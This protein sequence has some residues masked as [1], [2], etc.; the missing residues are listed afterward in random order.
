MALREK[1]SSPTFCFFAFAFLFFF[2]S[3]LEAVKESTPVAKGVIKPSSP[4]S[5]LPVQ[6]NCTALLGEKSTA[7]SD[8]DIALKCHKT[9]LKTGG[10]FQSLSRCGSHEQVIFCNDPSVGLKAIVALHSTALGPA[11]GGCRVYPY[12]SEEEAL[13]DV[14]RLSKGMTY[15][16]AISGLNFGGGKMVVIADPKKDKSEA[17]LRSLGRF[18][19]SLGGQFITGED[20]GMT[21]QDVDTMLLETPYVMG[22]STENGG[23]GNPGEYTAYGVFMGMKAVS[24]YLFERKDGNVEGLK[25][26]VQGLGNVGSNLVE[27]LVR[28]GAEVTVADVDQAKVSWHKDKYQVEVVET[29]QIAQ[30]ESDIFAPCALGAVVNAHSIPLLGCKAIA[31]SANNQLAESEHGEELQKK[32]ILYAPDYVINAGGLISVAS[33]IDTHGFLREKVLAQINNIYLRLM[34]IFEGAEKENT[35]T[36]LIADQMAEERIQAV[37]GIREKKHLKH[38][39]RG[40]QRE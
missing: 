4:S 1:S 40:E 15:K 29:E 32:G 19:H 33:E 3:F 18:M 6:R 23:A 22:V 24:K 16:N 27:H 13:I 34:E 8:K 25:I 21:V 14:L 26:A 36:H 20:M 17:M 35:S 37:G 31:G 38:I 10:V 2:T 39:P 11:T 30:I 9:R 12:Q 7:G 5:A 28:A